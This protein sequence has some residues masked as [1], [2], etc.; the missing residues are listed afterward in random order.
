MHVLNIGFHIDFEFLREAI[1]FILPIKCYLLWLISSNRLIDTSSNIVI[2]ENIYMHKGH[3]NFHPVI[4]INDISWSTQQRGERTCRDHI[5]RL[6][7]APGWGMGPPTHL[8][9]INP[10]LFLSKENSGTKSG[11]ETE[12]KAIERLSYLEI[13]PICRHQMQTLLLMPRSACW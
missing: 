5:Q 11:A 7:M 9:N 4:K 8:K 1:F 3:A 6:G 10:E 13:H 12:G 2:R